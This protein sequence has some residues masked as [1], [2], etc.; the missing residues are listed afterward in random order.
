MII[1]GE[2]QAGHVRDS[3]S[4]ESHRTTEGGGDSC[5]KS[6]Y[7]EEPVSDTHDIDAQIFCIIIAQHQGIERFDEQQTAQKTS[8]ADQTEPRHHPHGHTTKRAQS[9]HHI[10]AHTFVGSKIIEQRDGGVGNVAYHDADDEQHD[11]IA[12]EGGEK[13][14]KRHDRHST[15]ESCHHHSH[16]TRKTDRACR[17]ATTKEQHDQSHTQ[18]GTTVDAENAGTCQRIAESRLKHESTC[19]QSTAAK[20]SRQS[21][22][23]A[24]LQNDILPR[25]AHIVTAR[26]DAKGISEGDIDRAN[27]QVEEKQQD[28]GNSERQTIYDSFIHAVSD[29]NA[30]AWDLGC[31]DEVSE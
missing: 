28:D 30:K 29:N 1:G 9:P 27:H 12:H 13:E 23:Q 10:T 31:Q 24:R 17:Y 18:A 8:Y 22:R 4:D 11:V 26:Q 15:N 6:R 16:E 20:D 14:N 25:R 21:L 2:Q 7:N 5:E 19:C 3:Q